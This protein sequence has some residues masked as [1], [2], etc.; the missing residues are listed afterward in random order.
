MQIILAARNNDAEK[1]MQLLVFVVLAVFYALGSIIKAKSNKNKTEE[2][3][4]EPLRREPSENRR[5]PKARTFQ[6]TSHPQEQ[7]PFIHTA[8]RQSQPQVH[9]PHRKIVRPQP[10]MQKS[11]TKKQDFQIQPSAI[12]LDLKKT[13]NFA[14]KPLKKLE[15]YTG[16]PAEETLYT[17]YGEH[18]LDYGNPDELKRAILHY[19][20]LGKPLSLRESSAHILGF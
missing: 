4:K 9:P 6:K 13:K 17:K 15:G 12:D 8:H 3:R 1:W 2:Q 7:H 16:I 20:I 14:H 5:M 11:L 18:L 19:E 10:A